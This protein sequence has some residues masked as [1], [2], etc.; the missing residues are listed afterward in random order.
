MVNSRLCET[1]RPGFPTS[2]LQDAQSPKNETSRPITNASEISQKSYQNDHYFCRVCGWRLKCTG[3]QDPHHQTYFVET[4]GKK[5]PIYMV[6]F[7]NHFYRNKWN[8][9]GFKIKFLFTFKLFGQ[10]SILLT[11]RENSAC[12]PGVDI[13]KAAH[14]SSENVY[15]LFSAR[16]K[17]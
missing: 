4:K 8:K 11:S 3:K 10:M 7:S 6:I 9:H 5:K 15:F 13:Q 17:L 1:A 14:F 2:R 16:N 12:L